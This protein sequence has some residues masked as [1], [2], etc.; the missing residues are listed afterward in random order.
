MRLWNVAYM[1][2]SFEGRSFVE[3]MEKVGEN[4]KGRDVENPEET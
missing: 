4:L 1:N 3:L 2:D